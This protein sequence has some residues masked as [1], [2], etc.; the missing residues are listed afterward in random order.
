MK[1]LF[2]ALL[3]ALLCVCLCA[4]ALAETGATLVRTYTGG[5]PSLISDT[6]R[7]HNN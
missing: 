7:Y 1:K 3:A 5:T 2:A 4:S 6:N